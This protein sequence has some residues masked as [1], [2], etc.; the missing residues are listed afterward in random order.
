MKTNATAHL[1]KFLIHILPPFLIASIFAIIAGSSGAQ[2]SRTRDESRHL[3]R[4]VMLLETG[5]YRLNKH[6]PILPNILNALPLMLIDDIEIPSTESEEWVNAEKDRL[7]TEFTEINAPRSWF[8][9]HI[10]NPSR[11]VTV[12]F[13]AV[14]IVVMFLLV[15]RTWGIWTALIFSFLY[16]FEPNIIAHSSLATTDIWVVPFIFVATLFVYQYARSQKPITLVAFALVSFLSLITKFSAIPIA[17]L[18]LFIIF[19]I[20]WHHAPSPHKL[21]SSLAKPLIIISF[22]IFALSAVYR[23]Q[24]KSLADSN[25]GNSEKT[26]QHLDNISELTRSFVFLRKPLQ[27]AYVHLKLPFAEY[28]YGFF[29]NIILHNEYGH[30]TFLFGMYSKKGWWYYFPA[31]MAVKSPV[32]LLLGIAAISIAAVLLL[33]RI[34][35][36]LTKRSESL[37]AIF[38][39]HVSLNN[40]ILVVVPLFFLILSMK[41]NIN[42]GYRHI[43]PILPFMFLGISLFIKKCWSKGIIWKRSITLLA[44]WYLYSAISI[45][46]HYLSY[47]NELV[48]GPKNGYLYLLDS[49]LSWEQDLFRVDRYILNLPEGVEYH[50]NPLNEVKTG[51][52]IIDVDLLMGRDSAKREK[53]AWLREKFLEGKVEPVD[54]IGYTY[55][56]FDAEKILN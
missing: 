31:A 22:W 39:K 4:G 34:I 3:I 12:F 19:I 38:T 46:P 51:L 6:H 23:F 9:P 47:F 35:R 45:Y 43:L 30:D 13:S 36:D 20:E 26:A 54:R 49:N 56:V 52:I 1:K 21:L 53:T 33:Y 25:Y 8:V 7:A 32:P 18:W 48:G 11:T 5:D 37:N 17:V 16:A 44:L 10:L 2:Y 42:L 15:N 41:S 40:C 29:E 27:D 55:M 28:F 50:R 14:S 24:F